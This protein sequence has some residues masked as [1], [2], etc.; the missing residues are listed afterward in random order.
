MAGGLMQLVAYGAQ[1][2]YLTGNPQITFFKIVYR[3]Y[4]NFAIE[5]IEQSFIGT[6]KFGNKVTAKIPSSGDLINKVYVKVILNQVNVPSNNKF[7]WI[8]R[9]GHAI[10]DRV[11]LEIL[12]TTIDR[13]YGT[14]LDVWYELARNS[15]HDTGYAALIGDVDQLTAYNNVSKPEYTLFIP[16]QF[17]FNRYIGLAIP[18][19]A[20]QY[21]TVSI[22]VYFSN[23]NSL[24][25]ADT[26]FDNSDIEIKSANLL[27]NY[28]YLDDDERKRFAQVGHEYLIEQVQCN[29]VI[30]ISQLSASYTLDYNHPTK[31]IIW[32]YKNGNYTSGKRFIYYINSTNWSSYINDASTK[33][34]YESISIDINPSNIVGGIWTNIPPGSSSSPVVGNTGNISII[35]YSTSNIY[36]NNTSLIVN[37]TYGITSKITA[38]II[39]NSDTSLTINYISSGI[40]TRDLSIPHE[41]MTDT[42][43]NPIDPIVYQFNNYGV[44]ID[45]TINPVLNALIQFNGH[46]RFDQQPGTYFNYVQ[47]YKYHSNTPVDGINIYSFSLFPEQHQPSGTANLS[48]LDSILLI[49]EIGDSTVSINNITDN[50]LPPINLL[51]QN[52]QL[53]IFGTNYN[54]FRIMSGFA[55]LAYSTV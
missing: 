50:T 20:I 5:T 52:N 35:N 14:W 33:I 26:K 15:N 2:I 6:I 1:D 3:R 41:L 19:I 47:P 21:G 51:D 36:V 17:W 7:A 40:T 12:G 37:G 42:R 18:L 45:G 25:I 13:H 22:N 30:S 11:E 55:A 34:L 10:I 27:I 38:D 39:V 48:R 24:M 43:Y 28:V 31:E 4:T 29:G 49:L 53:W 32:A 16:L 54:I 23:K 9:L 46:N 8:R 44:L